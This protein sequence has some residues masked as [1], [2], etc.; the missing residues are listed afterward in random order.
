MTERSQ[1][2]EAE[3]Q[4][5]ADHE[6]VDAATVLEDIGDLFEPDNSELPPPSPDAPPGR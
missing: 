5:T 1:E 6:G 3:Q 2:V 4:A